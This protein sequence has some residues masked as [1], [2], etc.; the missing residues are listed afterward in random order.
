MFAPMDSLFC[1]DAICKRPVSLPSGAS[2]PWPVRCP[3]CGTALYPTDVLDRLPASELEPKRAELMRERDG[4]RVAVVSHE[5]DAP[6]PASVKNVSNP[7]TAADRILEKVHLDPATSEVAPARAEVG[8]PR[9]PS[10][11]LRVLAVL[12][13]ATVALAI[14]IVVLLR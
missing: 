9:H 10:R 2:P 6:R 8:P 11:R 13:A 1:G 3:E 5:L 14:V 12:V 7:D 4:R